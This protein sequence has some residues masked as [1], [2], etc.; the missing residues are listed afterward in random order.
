M[1]LLS[2]L[3]LSLVYG[4]YAQCMVPMLSVL[5]LSPQQALNLLESRTP[6]RQ[7]VFPSTA[8]VCCGS[9]PAP[10]SLLPV[11]PCLI[12]CVR[13]DSWLIEWSIENSDSGSS[14]AAWFGPGSCLCCLLA[15]VD[16]AS[17]CCLLAT[18]D[19][20]SLCCLLATVDTASCVGLASHC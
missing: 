13:A 1:L 17:L 14:A 6:H 15:T 18:V 2:A 12:E 5:R 7:R 16:T 19:T 8:Q 4:A 20:A 11:S 9:L 10:C 3:F